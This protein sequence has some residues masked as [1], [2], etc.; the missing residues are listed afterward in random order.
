MSARSGRQFVYTQALYGGSAAAARIENAAASAAAAARRLLVKAARQP[1][2]ATTDRL[3]TVK[4]ELGRGFKL[5]EREGR[6]GGSKL[7]RWAGWSGG[8]KGA[9]TEEDA[10]REGGREGESLREAQQKSSFSGHGR[11]P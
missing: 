11:L 1:L 3:P 2:L 9:G 6:R 5:K 4:R 8:N 7:R 10:G